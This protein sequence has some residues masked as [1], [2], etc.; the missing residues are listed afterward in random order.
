VSGERAIELEGTI[1]ERLS[2][3]AFR[4]ELANGHRM[5]GFTRLRDQDLARALGPGDR[6]RL[7]VSPFDFSSGCVRKK[8]ER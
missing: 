5:V 2:E 7:E 1:V 4:V 3:G 8:L 6:V